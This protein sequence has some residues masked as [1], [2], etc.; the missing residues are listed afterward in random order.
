VHTGLSAFPIVSLRDIVGTVDRAGQF[1]DRDFR[2]T[3]QRAR[4][5]FQRAYIAMCRSEPIP[6]VE[7]RRALTY[8]L[9]AL[10]AVRQAGGVI[11]PA[12]VTRRVAGRS[13][14]SGRCRRSGGLVA[15]TARRRAFRTDA[16]IQRFIA[17]LAL[18]TGPR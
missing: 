18:D 14:G 13:G 10:T 7:L 3:Q 15:G 5:R 16:R 17:L 2:P 6:P 12:R 1:F 4:E 9:L 11:P 8:E